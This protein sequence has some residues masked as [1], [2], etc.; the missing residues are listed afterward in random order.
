[1]NHKTPQLA[2]DLI[3][4]AKQEGWKRLDLG[5]TGLRAFPMEVLELVWLEELNLSDLYQD[6]KSKKWIISSNEG[7]DN[8]LTVIPLE[9]KQLCHLKKLRLG[10]SFVS[11][12]SI[13]DIS[14]L[15]YL[16]H[17]E[18]L[19]LSG[20]QISKIQGLQ[21]LDNLQFLDLNGN[22]ISKIQG[23]QQLSNL[24]FLDLSE[25]QINQIQ[26]LRQLNNLHTLNLNENQISKIQELKTLNNLQFLDLQTN[27]INQI[28]DLEQL[29]N[30]Q[31]LN[32]S[33]NQITNIDSLK[34]LKN[35]NELYLH[36]NL[37]P[38]IPTA[39]LGIG[40]GYDCLSDLKSW[41]AATNN[42]KHCNPNKTIKLLLTGNG[43]TGKS[44]LLCA[45]ENGK[46][47][48]P[49]GHNSTHGIVMKTLKINDITFQIW[50]FAGQEIY[51][52][53][54]QLF[55][56]G[57]AIQV[58]VFDPETEQKAKNR[59]WEKDRINEE[60]VRHHELHY[61]L[62]NAKKLSPSS[63]FIVVQNKKDIYKEVDRSIKILAAEQD[64]EFL[65]V[66]SHNG[67]GIKKLINRIVEAAEELNEYGMLMPKSWLKVR[68]YFIRNQGKAP[69]KRKRLLTAAE[70]NKRCRKAGLTGALEK[71]IPTLQKLLHHNGYLYYHEEYLKGQIIAD[72]EWA[73]EA[74]YSV[75]S[76]EGDFYED[77]TDPNQ[78]QTGKVRVRKLFRY[79]GKAYT[80]EYKW[81]FLNFMESC[82]LCFHLKHEGEKKQDENSNYIFPQFL[83][84]VP[85]KNSERLWKLCRQQ[86]HQI[87]HYRRQYDALGYYQIQRFIVALGQKTDLDNIWRTGIL[88][89]TPEG[90]FRVSADLANHRIDVAMEARVR[91]KWLP[92]I[93]E[94]LEGQRTKEA[95]L[96]EWQLE[97][98]GIYHKVSDLEKYQQYFAKHGEAA[99][100]LEAL[101][102]V[103][104]APE[105]K[106]VKV[107]LSYS[108][109][110]DT[111]KGA[112]EAHF[113]ASTQLDT[114]SETDL[115]LGDNR[116]VVMQRELDSADLILFLLS[117]DFLNDSFLIEEQLPRIL[118]RQ[119]PFISIQLRPMAYAPPALRDRRIIPQQNGEVV[120]I[121][122]WKDVE[123]AYAMIARVVEDFIRVELKK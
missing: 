84:S 90:F 71:T 66:S 35:L 18:V 44:S 29:K 102:T 16:Y 82:G 37:I 24:Q 33:S 60:Q 73:L 31:S 93:V 78:A 79:F 54:H 104:A 109:K 58:I 2:L 70:F 39:L 97:E 22:Q 19:D 75:L 4:Q 49:K 100:Q 6:Y 46:C 15:Q 87:L 110:D 26:G 55:M 12:R 94:I 76:R 27:Q 17:L 56:S 81:L 10:G 3:Q 11:K 25:N 118:E 34:S 64:A 45:L 69:A 120:P 14:P 111:M 116:Q 99:D 85:S 122:A 65:Q 77:M 7:K 8:H 36:S 112:L 106:R 51:H 63:Q 1:M 95:T 53:T 41:W 92:T 107:F 121:S 80:S 67:I 98:N 43:G 83:S 42:P 74:I 72:Q 32:L 48:C 47:T 88:V 62:N 117:V 61:W 38:K 40:E 103:Y 28:Q 115:S 20:N 23:L 59:T 50:D 89:E 96:A 119:T 5:R 21:Q 86:G 108:R 113:A 52:G 105:A 9:I 68:N 101:K 13:K 123:E 91:D 30:L 114:W 57:E